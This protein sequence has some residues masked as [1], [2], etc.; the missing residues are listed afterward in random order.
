MLE[1]DLTFR[2]FLVSVNGNVFYMKIFN[3]SM[4]YLLTFNHFNRGV[5][6]TKLGIEKECGNCHA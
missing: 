3:L 4:R 1:N 2:E 6:L 5:V